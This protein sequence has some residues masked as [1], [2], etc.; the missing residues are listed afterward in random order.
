MELGTSDKQMFLPHLKQKVNG[1]SFVM[2]LMYFSNGFLN[3]CVALTQQSFHD[4]FPNLLPQ[5]K[6]SSFV[7]NVF[8]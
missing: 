2:Y 4:L 7:P 5:P 8:P 1:D 3:S 6:K